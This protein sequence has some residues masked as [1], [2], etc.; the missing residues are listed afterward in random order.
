MIGSVIGNGREARCA[1]WM[2]ASETNYKAICAVEK[3]H[4]PTEIGSNAR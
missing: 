2:S 1:E 3:A 4:N